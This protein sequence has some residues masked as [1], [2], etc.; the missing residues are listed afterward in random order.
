MWSASCVG[1]SVRSL[2]I[3]VW[4]VDGRRR[5]PVVR[6]LVHGLVDRRAV[7][8]SEHLQRFSHFHQQHFLVEVAGGAG[9]A[10]D[11]VRGTL[12]HVDPVRGARVPGLVAERSSAVAAHNLARHANA[13]RLVSLWIRAGC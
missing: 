8:P 12:P 6:K 10:L 11:V 5:T 4:S 13:E 3:A 2:S 7:A 9:A 1:D